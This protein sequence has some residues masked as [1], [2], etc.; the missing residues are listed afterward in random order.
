MN[1]SLRQVKIES[2]QTMFITSTGTVLFTSYTRCDQRDYCLTTAIRSV[3]DQGS[4]VEVGLIKWNQ[5]TGS[6]SLRIGKAQME[7][8]AIGKED[9]L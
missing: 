9:S 5:N 4:I 3:D 7:L 6:V 2:S 1:I 8:K